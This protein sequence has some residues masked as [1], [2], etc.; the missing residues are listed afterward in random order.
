MGPEESGHG[1]TSNPLSTTKKCDQL[2]FYIGH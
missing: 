2:I 1:L